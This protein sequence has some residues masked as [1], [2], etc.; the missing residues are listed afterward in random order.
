M[1]KPYKI[2]KMSF[3]C[4]NGRI[5]EHNVHMTN[6]YQYRDIANTVCKENQS[7]GN[8]IWEQ[9][10]PSPKY[11]VEDFYLVHASLFNEILAPF[12]MEVEPPKR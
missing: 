2:R 11:T 9:D 5:I 10:K 3:I 8:Y 12:C 1:K 6:A 7:R 4:K